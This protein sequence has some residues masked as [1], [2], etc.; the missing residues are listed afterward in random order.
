MTDGAK[1]KDHYS[2]EELLSCARGEMFGPGNAQLPAPPMLL[3]DRIIRIDDTGGAHGKGYIE[4][5]FDINPDLW[6]FDC[7][8]IG[9]P[10]MPGSLGLDALWQLVGFYLGWIGGKGRGRA[11]GCGEVRFGGEVTPNIKKVTY[12]IEMKRVINRRLVMGIGDG[13]LEADGEPIYQ[14]ADLRVGLYVRP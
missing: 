8:F 7:H 1:A 4:A 10:V 5:E 13:V 3:F 14:A 11:L 12:K 9:D 6:F 2:F